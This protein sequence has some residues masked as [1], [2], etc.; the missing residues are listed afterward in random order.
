MFKHSRLLVALILSLTL[1][2]CGLLIIGGAT[3]GAGA[4]V[5][6][7]GWLQAE[8]PAQT[9]RVHRAAAAALRDLKWEVD[10]HEFDGKDGTVD[11]FQPNGRR[12]VVKVKN[13]EERKT[14]VRIR[15]GIL[16]NKAASQRILDQ[17]KKNL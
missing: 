13:L 12:V 14:R 4:I 6:N 10:L 7:A 17:I 2:G 11:A 1:T 5:W 8:L 9:Q 15:V 3:V 16:G